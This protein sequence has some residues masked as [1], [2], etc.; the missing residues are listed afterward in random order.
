MQV[1]AVSLP[2]ITRT[3]SSSDESTIVIAMPS[4]TEARDIID[5]ALYALLFN[6]AW[7]MIDVVTTDDEEVNNQAISL[8]PAPVSAVYT[9][10]DGSDSL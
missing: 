2:C 3:A 8:S 6:H 7:Q 9:A 1:I 5:A 10:C 4:D